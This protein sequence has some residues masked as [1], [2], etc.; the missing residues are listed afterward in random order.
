MAFSEN[1]G[2]AIEAIATAIRA[3]RIKINGNAPDLSALATTNKGNLVAA[4]NEILTLVQSSGT[5]NVAIN[6]TTASNTSVYSSNKVA[7]LL[8]Q[9]K[10]DIL[11]GASAAYDTLKE[12]QDLMAADDTADTSFVNATNTALGNRVRFDST[13][14]LTTAQK[15]VA[16]TNIGAQEA[17]LIGD[18]SRDFVAVF[19]AA[20]L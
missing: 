11:G 3:D 16:R 6:D 17:A 5:S 12:L 9:W 20:I 8:A 19:N 15:G 10:Q 18:T 14:T 13:Q 7:A 1:I 4:I 2:T